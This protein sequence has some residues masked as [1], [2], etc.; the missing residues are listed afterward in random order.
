MLAVAFRLSH[1]CA[2]LPK[3][4]PLGVH[5]AAGR[6]VGREGCAVCRPR[7]LLPLAPPPLDGCIRHPDLQR[8]GAGA[9]VAPTAC[10]MD[11]Q[12]AEPQPTLQA[13]GRGA[14]R[15]ACLSCQ[16]HTWLSLCIRPPQALML[17]WALL[18]PL[19]AG[20][21]PVI[22]CEFA[23]HVLVPLACRLLPPGCKCLPIRLA[24]RP[25]PP[26]PTVGCSRDCGC[27]GQHHQAEPTEPGAQGRPGQPA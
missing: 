17:A 19:T 23:G 21:Q 8:R 15:A 24:D 26:P 25:W 22:W 3:R 7:P 6:R 20:T 4:R 16:G 1:C 5:S 18:S 9:C 14:R 13:A 2:V 10:C 12:C 11:N 27:G